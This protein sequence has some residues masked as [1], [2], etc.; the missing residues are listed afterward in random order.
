MPEGDTIFKA[1]RTL[2]RALAGR[3]VTRFE[4]GLAELA[5][6]DRDGPIAGR[7]VEGVAAAGKHLLI[8]FSGDLVLRSHMRMNGSWHIYRPGERWQ[9]PRSAM[10]IVIETAD[11]VAVAFRVHAAEFVRATDLARHRPIATLGPDLLAQSFDMDEAVRRIRAHAQRPIADALLDQRAVAGIGNVYKSEVLFLARVHPDTPV[12]AIDEAALHTIIG[13]A[14]RLL[15]DN[16]V[17]RPGAG[18]VTYRSG[19]RTTGRMRPEDRLWVYSRAG[20]PC[21]ACAT[22]IASRKTGD[23]ARL[24]YWC[25]QCQRR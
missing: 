24:T 14:R 23:D 1:A 22:P 18:M 16:V 4:T 11:W 21:R 7:T 15:L 13:I 3:P 17:E 19:R 6:I 8:T 5:R 10:R 25:P 2:D 20:Q 9:L 12:A